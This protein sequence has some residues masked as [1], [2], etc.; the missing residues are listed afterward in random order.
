MKFKN[1]IERKLELARCIAIIKETS[2]TLNKAKL[3]LNQKFKL[4]YDLNLYLRYLENYRIP[5]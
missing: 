1:T 5:E 2:F 4:A 3:T